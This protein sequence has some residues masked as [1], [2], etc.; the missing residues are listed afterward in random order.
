MGDLEFIDRNK[1]KNNG[2]TVTN[3]DQMQS[4]ILTTAK[5]DFNVY[6][7]R[8][9][10]LL[11]EMAQC[12]VEG[13]SFRD[14]CYKIEHNL[15]GFVNVTIPISLILSGETDKN[16]ALAKK[17]VDDLSS[18]AFYYEDNHVWE[19]LCIIVAPSIKKNKSTISFI[20]QPRIWSVILDFSKGFRK[21]ELATAMSF[22]S[23]YSMRF[24]ELLSGQKSPITYKVD[25]LKEI[26]CVQDKYK[27]VSDFRRYVIEPAR[28]EL[29]KYAPY[30]FT[31]TPVKDGRK[32]VGFTF[33]PKYNPK[34]RDEQLERKELQKKSSL[35]WQL[36]EQVIDYLT[37]SM[38]FTSEE[39]KR[40]VD[41]F[42]MAENTFEDILLEL[43]ILHGKSRDKSNPKGWII[44]AIKGKL[45][46]IGK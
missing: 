28:K 19:K 40:N 37:Q 33:F 27:L 16:H 31:Y 3:K 26:F 41:L 14:G 30:S 35:S 46:D 43:S 12:E 24:Y 44:N 8:I 21:Y 45:H 39:I 6:E 13:R 25:Y 32:I 15:W 17:A 7:K 5:Y 36:H 34:N 2:V 23:V 1:G 4:Y 38:D 22:K 18:K 11:V 9:L 29:D 20:V 42:T 10:Y